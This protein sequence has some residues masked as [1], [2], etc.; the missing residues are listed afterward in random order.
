MATSTNLEVK[1]LE[2]KSNIYDIVSKGIVNQNNNSTEKHWRGTL[3]EYKEQDI[4]NQHP[5]WICYITDD[6]NESDINV[7][8]LTERINGILDIFNLIYPIGSIYIGTQS[9][10]PMSIA[11]PNSTWELLEAGRA[12]WTGSGSNGN[13]TIEAGLPN[14]TGTAVGTST[15]GLIAE[16]TGCFKAGEYSGTVSTDSTKQRGDI[17]F[18][19]SWSNPIYGNSDTVQPPAYVVNVWRRIA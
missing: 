7:G 4:E 11:I 2:V 9:I 14:I 15:R 6:V 1:E 16:G 3:A 8:S 19:A 13:T 17:L 12:L 18:D 10:C 5:D